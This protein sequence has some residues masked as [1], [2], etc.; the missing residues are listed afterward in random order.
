LLNWREINSLAR[1]YYVKASELI[2]QSEESKVEEK[3]EE[4]ES[5]AEKLVDLRFMDE[6]LR[7]I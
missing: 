4:Y 1:D 3:A 7:I 2:G 5:I 6:A